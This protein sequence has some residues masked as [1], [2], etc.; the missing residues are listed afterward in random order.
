MSYTAIVGLQWGD[1]GKGKVIDYLARDYDVVVRF[2]GGANAGHSVYANGKSFVFHL[3][4][5]GMLWEDVVG[6]IGPGVVIDPEA[7]VKEISDLEK[8]VGDLKG[9]LFVDPRAHIVMPYHRQ[10]DALFEASSDKPIGT[11]KKGI[12]P[13]NRDRYGRL[14]IR[15]GD[16]LR[17]DY[18]REHLRRPYDFN[19]RVVESYGGVMPPFEEIYEY[20]LEFGERI[21]PYVADGVLRDLHHKGGGGTLP[22]RGEGR[23]GG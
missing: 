5:S 17:R 1:E 2:Q 13:T 12:G 15:V 19:K 20:L 21:S 3:I 14:G 10:E 4:P 11:T 6:V 16:T 22:D 18:L 8:T 9:R 23:A 7:F